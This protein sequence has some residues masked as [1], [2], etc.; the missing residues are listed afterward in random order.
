MP[1]R[2]LKKSELI[3]YLLNGN[4]YQIKCPKDPETRQFLDRERF[5]VE[6]THEILQKSTTPDWTGYFTFHLTN[7]DSISINI[8]QICAVQ[9]QGPQEPP[10]EDE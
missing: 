6:L 3:I 10:T 4:S 9:G 7:G 1:A 5:I 2:K 8:R